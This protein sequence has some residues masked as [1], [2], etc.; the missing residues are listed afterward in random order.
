MGSVTEER[1]RAIRYQFAAAVQI[2]GKQIGRLRDMSTS[3]FFFESEEALICGE[4]VRLKLILTG[5]AVE[6]E[7]RVVRAEQLESRFGI[8][9]QIISF[10]FC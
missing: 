7:G 10:Q 1:R 6:C 3:G 5:S 9:V 8:A 4:T 2:D